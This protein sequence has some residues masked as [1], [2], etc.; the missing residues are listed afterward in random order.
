MVNLLKTDCTFKIREFYD[1]YTSKKLF[2]K[3]H[4]TGKE[5]IKLSL[6]V[7]SLMVCIVNFKMHQLL[8]LINELSKVTGYKVTIV[9]NLCFYI[10]ATNIQWKQNNTIY[11][12]SQ[13]C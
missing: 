13:K 7:D 10:M 1:I 3:T 6:F 12:S 11:N 8:G 5:E 4:N 2:L 9:N